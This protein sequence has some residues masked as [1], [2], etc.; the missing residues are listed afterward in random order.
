MALNRYVLT[1]TVTTV[2]DVA[3]T[4]VTGLPATNGAEFG[5]AA[6]ASPATAGK[7]GLFPQTFLVGTTI[8]LDPAPTNGLYAALGGAANLRPYVQGQ[9]DRGGAAL[10]NLDS[11]GPGVSSTSLT[12]ESH[13][14][15]DDSPGSYC[16]PLMTSDSQDRDRQP[17]G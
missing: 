16:C 15:D 8:M 14:G 17:G 12:T 9:D 2:P 5:S 3:A 4:P 7:Y 1:S 6:T 11:G 13:D 10:S